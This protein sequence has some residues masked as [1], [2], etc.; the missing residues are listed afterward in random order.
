MPPTIGEAMR[1]MI[2]E[3]VPLPVANHNVP[4]A[5]TYVPQEGRK[6]IN[7]GKGGSNSQH[8]HYARGD[9]TLRGVGC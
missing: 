8:W 9:A 7:G 3:P 5:C 2:C 6:K 4:G 1:R